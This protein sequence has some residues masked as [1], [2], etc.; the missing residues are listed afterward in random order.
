MSD[1]GN[2][3]SV[4]E[5]SRINVFV[6]PSIAAVA[7]SSVCVRARVYVCVCVRGGGGGGG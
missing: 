4:K 1:K 2:M 7:F 3:I 5:Y 6:T